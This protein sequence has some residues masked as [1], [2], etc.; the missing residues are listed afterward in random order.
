MDR[1]AAFVSPMLLLRTERLPEGPNWLYELKFDGYRSLAIKTGGKVQLRSRND[2]DFNL[3]Y[4]AIVKAL[5]P[6]P[7]QTVIDGEVVALDQNGKPSF[8]KLQNY[9]S[10]GAPLHYFVFDLLILKGKDLTA[11]PLFKRRQLLE[12]TSFRKWM[13]L[14]G[15]LQF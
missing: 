13:S 8:N 5:A 1:K 12:S 11:E 14:S 4:P 3:R 9:G 7:D 2:N 10:A 6:M 15:I